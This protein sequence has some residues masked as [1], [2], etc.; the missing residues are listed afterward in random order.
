VLVA[1]DLAIGHGNFLVRKGWLT[2]A[3]ISP[4]DH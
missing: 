2:Y 4:Y 1:D 3:V